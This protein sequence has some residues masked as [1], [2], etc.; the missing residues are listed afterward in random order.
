MTS[1]WISFGH[2]VFKIHVIEVAQLWQRKIKEWKQNVFSCGDP[3]VLLQSPLVQACA[4][5][6]PTHTQAHTHIYTN[7]QPPPCTHSL[8]PFPIFW[9]TSDMQ[10]CSVDQTYPNPTE[11]TIQ[12]CGATTHTILH[13]VGQ[14]KRERQTEE[15]G[16]REWDGTQG[17][18]LK[19]T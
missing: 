4:F 12:Q 7:T 16:D 5:F 13:C 1:D 14:R 8:W 9:L 11:T 17:D 10:C 2:S 19:S 3:G 15:P 6:D 18:T